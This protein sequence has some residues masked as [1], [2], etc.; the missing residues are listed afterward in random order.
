MGPDKKR[1]FITKSLRTIVI[2]NCVFWQEFFRLHWSH[3]T[4]LFAIISISSQWFIF[5][6]IL[7]YGLTWTL[8]T[9]KL[10]R[11]LSIKVHFYSKR[12][13]RKREVDRIPRV[14][15]ERLAFFSLSSHFCERN[16]NENR[17]RRLICSLN[18]DFDSSDKSNWNAGFF[19]L[20]C[21]WN[22]C[23]QHVLCYKY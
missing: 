13:C 5:D 9:Q 12:N 8:N 10:E 3:D 21:P 20:E 1:F 2:S 23:L 19:P 6:L 14:R 7:F 22:W 4:I 18:V 16:I 15:N 17:R 11:E